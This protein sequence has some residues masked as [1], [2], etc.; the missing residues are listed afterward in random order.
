VVE[1]TIT[2]TVVSRFFFKEPFLPNV[3][4]RRGEADDEGIDN[5]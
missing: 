4:R 2:S 1:A 3:V 5:A